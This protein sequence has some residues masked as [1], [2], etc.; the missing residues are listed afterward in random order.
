M[1]SHPL[2]FARSR[3]R[4][5][6][7]R[8]LFCGL[9]MPSVAAAQPAD[10]KATLASGMRSAA[11]KD[12]ARAATEFAAAHTVLPSPDALE[13]LANAQYQQRHDAEAY[14]AYDEWL[15]TYGST[16]SSQK[17]KLS[18]SRLKELADRT[19]LLAFDVSEVGATV[20]VDERPVGTSPLVTA[21]RLGQGPHRVRVTKDGF[22]PFDQ[23][24]NVAPRSTQSVTAKLDARTTK[25]RLVVKE[26]AGKAIR[27]LVDGIDMGDAPWTGDVDAGPHEV[28]GRGPGVA[29]L[30]ERRVVERA[31]TTDIDL[32]ASS[33]TSALKVSTSDGKGLIYL[34]SKLV[35]EGVFSQEVPAGTHVLRISREGYEPF[36][37]SLELKDKETLARSI[38]LMLSTKI[39]TR[40]VQA[41]SRPLEGLYGGF[42]LLMTWLPGGMKHAMQK[43]CE[44]AK[45]AELT[46]CEG[47]TGGLGGGITGFVGYH[48][49]PVGIELFAGAHY[50]Q[51]SPSLTWAASTTDPGLGPDPARVES[52]VVRRVGGFGIV[53]VRLTFQ[54][55]ALRF[56]LAGGVGLAYS[57]LHLSRET[58][59]AANSNA[60]DVFAPDAE[61]YLSPV[62]SL[63]PSIQYR[64]TGHTTVAL[65]LSLLVESPRS[66]DQIPTTPKSGG[67]SLGPS[68][69]TTP[70]YELATG[71]QV[72]IGPF[73]G[74]MFGP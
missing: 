5:V 10:P 1:L 26:K 70:A 42:G 72:Y 62:L 66:F 68:G 7:A 51:S 13:G 11:S 71:T 2:S 74:M 27:V 50:D 22:T 49:D 63:E 73:I 37:E 55:E 35:G 28:G 12:W 58:T 43:T 8:V 32:V 23:V 44:G 6:L 39:D 33:R 67:R 29:V 9:L 3:R 15:K 40:A 52:F 25:G 48:W 45:P 56:G 59:A 24:P 17:K 18:E 38:T 20:T 34:D 46:A 41:E 64:L 57:S 19:G 61:G 4:S 69:L 36:E 16:A 31:T 60:R 21:L 53:R 30:S 47:A 65:G 14:A 54:S